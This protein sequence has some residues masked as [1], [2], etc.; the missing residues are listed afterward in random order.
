MDLSIDTKVNTDSIIVVVLGFMIA[1][2]FIIALS[3]IA[4]N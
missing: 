4:K 1:G 3:K 2:A